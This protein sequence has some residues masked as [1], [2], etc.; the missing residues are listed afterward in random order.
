MCVLL[1][2][3]SAGAAGADGVAVLHGDVVPRGKVR[4]KVDRFDR[5]GQVIPRFRVRFTGIPLQC[6]G[7]EPETTDVR[8]S[9]Y[10]F[11]DGRDLDATVVSVAAGEDEYLTKLA[12]KLR[13]ESKGRVE[14]TVRY[15]DRQIGAAPG[16]TDECDSGRLAWVAQRR[17]S[18]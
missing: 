6:G 13:I 1:L 17:P 9:L 12:V 16:V 15:I 11:N 10:R 14:G 3:G 2:L 7:D 8:T 5:G 4:V 18:R